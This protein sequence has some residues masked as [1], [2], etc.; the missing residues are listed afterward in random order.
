LCWKYDLPK[1]KHTVRLK[2]L[3]PSKDEEFNSSEAII[4]SDQLING[5]KV[6]EDAAKK[7]F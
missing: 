6:N 7:S 5:M 3:N 4:Y 1:G 2:I